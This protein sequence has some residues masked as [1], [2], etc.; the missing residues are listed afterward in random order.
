M[1][2]EQVRQQYPEQ[3][4]VIEALDAYSENS[5]RHV[6]RMAVVA[7]CCDGSQALQTYKEMHH[8]YP[9]REFYFVHTN[10][11]DLRIEEQ[12]WVGIRGL[13]SSHEAHI[14]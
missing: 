8:Q 1:K 12:R 6:D 4:L 3:W 13:H 10:R 2:W 9:E 11:T 5:L 7:A 14:R